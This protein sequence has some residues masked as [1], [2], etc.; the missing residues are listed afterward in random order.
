MRPAHLI[1]AVVLALLA[2]SGCGVGPGERADEDVRL[3][4]TRDF[5]A[6]AV[7]A[8]DLAGVPESETVMRLL[9]RNSDVETR[10]GGKFV[11]CI[12]ELCGESGLG[13]RMVFCRA[14]LPHQDVGQ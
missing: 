2:L 4:V 9:Q 5:G 3:T 12:G 8:K 1:A 7:L 11:Q 10:Y 13:W 14:G 6:S